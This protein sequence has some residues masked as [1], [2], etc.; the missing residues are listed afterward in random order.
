MNI[1]QSL[2]SDF[3]LLR[4]L[5]PINKLIHIGAGTGNIVPTYQAW[6]VPIALFVE[7]DPQ[8]YAQLEKKID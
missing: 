1:I 3:A 6:K 5:F 7:A 2:P 8:I 4:Q